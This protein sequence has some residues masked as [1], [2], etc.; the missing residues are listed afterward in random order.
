MHTRIDDWSLGRSDWTMGILFAITV[1]HPPTTRCQS[2]FSRITSGPQ[3]ALQ[4]AAPQC[5]VEK[6]DFAGWGKGHIARAGTH[7]RGAGRPTEP[8]CRRA[9][10]VEVPLLSDVSSQSSASIREAIPPWNVR[11]QSPFQPGVPASAQEGEILFAHLKRIP[12][13][14]RLRLRGP[15][16]AR[17]ASSSQ[18]PPRNPSTPA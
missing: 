7:H 9:K 2:A 3:Q 16:G 1:P 17:D 6:R 15:T 13:L 10:R 4:P 12:K 8:K 11:T 5:R 14:D 18:Q